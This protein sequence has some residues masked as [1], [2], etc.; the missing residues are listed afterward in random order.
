M[1]PK[2]SPSSRT[3]TKTDTKFTE[4]GS[5]PG[6]SGIRQGQRAVVQKRKA[7]NEG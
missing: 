5:R 3:T 1:E 6:G 2:G 4:R 7:G